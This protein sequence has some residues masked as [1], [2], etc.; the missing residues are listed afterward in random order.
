MKLGKRLIWLITATLLLAVTQLALCQNVAGGDFI[1]SDGSTPPQFYEVGER[2]A[3]LLPSSV[4]V[5]MS[6]SLSVVV[7]DE[8]GIDTVIGSYKKDNDTIWTNTTMSFYAELTEQRYLYSARPLNFTLDAD[9]RLMVWD[10]VY[11]ASD[12]LGNWNKSAQGSVS[13]CFFPADDDSILLTFGPAFV[14]GVAIVG[15]IVVIVVIRKRYYQD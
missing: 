3:D 14:S 9:N 1:Q 15:I 13:Y 10:V 7:R 4:P 6:L 11:Y 2:F 12:T 5:E 8:D